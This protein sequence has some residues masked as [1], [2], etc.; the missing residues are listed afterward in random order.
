MFPSN[1]PDWPTTDERSKAG[2]ASTGGQKS[3]SRTDHPEFVSVDPAR[4]P[5]RRFDHLKAKGEV[6]GQELD[7]STM[8]PPRDPRE[9]KSSRAAYLVWQGSPRGQGHG[10]IVSGLWRRAHRRWAMGRRRWVRNPRRLALGPAAEPV[11]WDRLLLP[12]LAVLPGRLP[13]AAG[14][15]RRGRGPE[16]KDVTPCA[17]RGSAPRR[18]RL[19]V[20]LS[21]WR[22]RRLRRDLAVRQIELGGSAAIDPRRA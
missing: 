20:R 16:P 3:S 13:P 15:G 9:A 4:R 10:S 1:V 12:A 14:S 8:G 22:R 2:Q 17:S 6:G 19:D 5:A 18:N 11:G 21:G 7:L